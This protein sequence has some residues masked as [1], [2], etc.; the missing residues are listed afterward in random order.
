M[1]EITIFGTLLWLAQNNLAYADEAGTV[2]IPIW[3]PDLK[4]RPSF[5]KNVAKPMQLSTFEDNI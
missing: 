5:K 2:L 3:S 1:L 4:L